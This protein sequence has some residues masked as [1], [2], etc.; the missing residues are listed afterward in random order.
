[1]TIVCVDDH[2]IMLQGLAQNIRNI[3]PKASTYVFESADKAF[4]FVKDNGCDGILIRSRPFSRFFSF[5]YERTESAKKRS[6]FH[7]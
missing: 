2:P 1:M 7:F 6:R 4:D 3:L 5:Q